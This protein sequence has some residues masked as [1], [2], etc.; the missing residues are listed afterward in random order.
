MVENDEK[1]KESILL[2][3]TPK[4]EITAGYHIPSGKHIS[5][6]YMNVLRHFERK[7]NGLNTW[8]GNLQV[9]VSELESS[10]LFHL[11]DINYKHS[12]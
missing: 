4:C 7:G 5:G 3:G 8:D 12:I 11:S 9:H 6:Y 10:I 1:P 2:K